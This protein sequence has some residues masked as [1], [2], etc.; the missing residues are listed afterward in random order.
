MPMHAQPSIRFSV[1]G[2]NHA[3]IYGQVKLLLRAGAEFVSFYA[4]EPELAGAFQAAFPD[5]L[6]AR[7]EGEILEDTSIHVV[8]SASIPAERAPL[9]IRVMEHGKDFMS[10]KPGFTTLEQLDQ[11]RRVQ[12]ETGRIYSI[13][14][15]ER[16]EVPATV[17]A[18]ELVAQGA[19]GKVVQTV[20]LGPHRIAAATR[21]PWF[22]VKD[23]YGGI[24]TDIASHQ[25]DQFLFFTGSTRAEVVSA[26]VGNFRH[27]QYPELEDFGDAVLRGDGGTGYCR[28]DWYTPDGLDTWGDGRLVVLGTE[29]YI[30]VRKYTDIGRDR[31]GGDHLFLVDHEGMHYMDCKGGDLPYGR[32]LI[33]DVLNRTETAMP[34]AHCFLAS[35]LALRA[36]AVATRADSYQGHS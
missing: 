23:R 3:H 19:I 31:P 22:F 29:G 8:V 17:R 14:F 36:E 13:C 27:P 25:M 2:L 5:A 20:G 15:S 18:G 10:D 34:Q 9:G 26:Q 35:E 33:A 21:P 6:L 30:E 28:V 24:L 32:Q 11:A 7:S 4:P 16:L 1:I 12:K